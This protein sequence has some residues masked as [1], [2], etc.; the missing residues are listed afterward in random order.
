M[1]TTPMII[2]IMLSIGSWDLLDD[3]QNGIND[4]T[5][6]HI[7]EAL[8]CDGVGLNAGQADEAQEHEGDLDGGAHLVGN[9]V[10]RL[11]L[12]CQ[13][14]QA[15]VTHEA[16]DGVSNFCRDF[17]VTDDDLASNPVLTIR[18]IG[19]TKLFHQIL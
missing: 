9:G 1:H 15:Q 13:L 2:K 5:L 16:A 4:L 14:V 6:F 18:Q 10:Q 11:L 8:V 17:A 19:F 12:G 3:F 7:D